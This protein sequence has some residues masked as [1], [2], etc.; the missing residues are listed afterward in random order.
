MLLNALVSM[1]LLAK[2]DGH[3]RNTAASARYFVAGSP[4]NARPGLLHTAHMWQRW[5]NLTECVRTG[6]AVGHEEIVDR[7]EEWTTAFIAAMHRGA[8]E[9]APLV[10]RA[11]GARTIRKM[12]D[13][14]GGSGA[15]SIAFAHA[16]PDLRAD[17]F[18][19]PQV[20]PIA[21]AHVT[22]AGLG[23]R[24]TTRTGDL[25][26]D[27]FGA[28]YDLVL[29]S[30]ICHMLNPSENRDLL[31][32]CYAALEPGGLI[33]IQEFILEPDKTAPKSATLFSLNMLVGTLRGASYSVDEYTEWL[34]AAAFEDVRRVRIPGPS[35]LMLAGKSS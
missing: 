35:D 11:V 26:L 1:G 27:S 24:I 32:R 19:L 23:S 28:G 7:G 18:D 21:R 25:R 14:G 30:S 9:R 17:V 8:T 10:V 16:H 6:T 13:V 29:L 34:L 33:V 31:R 20:V 2:S 5:T 4:D 12:L 22:S 15:Y 3:Y